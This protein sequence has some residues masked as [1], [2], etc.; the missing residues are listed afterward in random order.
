MNMLELQEKFIGEL[1]SGVK[2][3]W[4]K[5][6]LHYEYF[7]W[8]GDVIENYIS[9]IYRD[10]SA[11]HL[12]LSVDALDILLALRQCRPEGQSEQWTWFEFRIDS[13]GAYKFDYKYDTPPLAA[14]EIKH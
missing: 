7:E 8:E 14:E 5:V 10:Q 9:K 2:G 13:K 6:E 4:D 11:E 1:L 3:P 12:S